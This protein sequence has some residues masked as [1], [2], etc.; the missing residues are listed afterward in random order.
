MRKIA[1]IEE[2]EQLKGVSSEVVDVIREAVTILDIE[3]GQSRD[4]DHGNGG[5]VIIIE[6]KDELQR[7]KEIHIDVKIA[8]PEY[9]DKIQC[10][11]GQIF[12]SIL[13]LL[14]NDFGIIVVMPMEFIYYTNWVV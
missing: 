11:D 9:A 3:Y 6:S 1:H 7:L 8:I 10:N 12:V 13:V 14:N 4:V 2:V 5:Y